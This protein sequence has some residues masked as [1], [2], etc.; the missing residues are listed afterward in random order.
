MPRSPSTAVVFLSPGTPVSSPSSIGCSLVMVFAALAGA[1]GATANGSSS[2]AAT[3]DVGLPQGDAGIDAVGSEPC[4]EAA[5][6]CTTPPAAECVDVATLRTYDAAGTCTGGSCTYE[7][8]D[9][10]CSIGCRNGACVPAPS[11]I[12]SLTS[13]ISHSCIS[14]GGAVACSIGC[15]NGACVPAP[16]GITS[17]TSNISHSCISKGGAVAC[18][19]VSYA[20]T[21]TIIRYSAVP[22]APLSSGVLTVSSGG[23]ADYVIMQGGG[24]KS[25]GP[26]QYGQLGNGSTLASDVPVEVSGLTSGVARVAASLEFACARTAAGGVMC[27]GANDAGQLGSGTTTGSPSPVGVVGLQSNVTA[28][29]TGDRHACALTT[30]GGV[31]CWGQNVSGELGNGS[32]T[33]SLVPVDVVGL[34][35]VVR[36]A[37]GFRHTCAV[38]SSGAIACWGD[39]S[40]G[41]L[42]QGT[43]VSSAVPVTVSGIT[44]AVA[45]ALG[46]N[47]SCSLTSF[48]GGVKC[49]GN[50]DHGQLGQS[51][52]VML[53]SAVPVDITNLATGVVAISAGFDFGCALASV[54]VVRCWGRGDQGQLGDGFGT[55]SFGPVNVLGL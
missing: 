9:V 44:Q 47:H 30:A 45:I 55:A 41:Q 6:T 39:N 51:T 7:H 2:D 5:I 31:K 16:S 19:G 15:R 1:C 37:A 33:G 20:S 43:Q 34:S 38:K 27:W 29:A 50:N 54:G 17:L 18:W 24:L 52:N 36:I 48:G 53:S 40:V 23:L 4:V 14:K 25:W 3:S 21:S 8:T 46:G 10:A 42:G 11:G 12:T 28:V 35:S 49:W 26:N 13:N 32:T 22:Y